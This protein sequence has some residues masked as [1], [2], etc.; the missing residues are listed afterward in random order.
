ML[1]STAFR[2]QL[3]MTDEHTPAM[4]ETVN[5]YLNDQ[6]VMAHQQEMRRQAGQRSSG[7]D[8]NSPQVSRRRAAARAIVRWRRSSRSAG[9]Y[10]RPVTA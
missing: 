4:E 5:Y 9:A 6:L 3:S 7:M 10:H 2:F 1:A 8:A